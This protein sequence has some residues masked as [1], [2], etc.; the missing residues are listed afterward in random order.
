VEITT[1]KIIGLA[2]GV[3]CIYSLWSSLT[4]PD[5]L[6]RANMLVTA[7]VSGITGLLLLFTRIRMINHPGVITE[8]GD[9]WNNPARFPGPFKQN[10]RDQTRLI[11]CMRQFRKI[12]TIIST[13][14]GRL[15]VD[16][17]IS[18]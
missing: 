11:F 5:F 17:Y 8:V 9:A 4:D 7:L 15:W 12:R 13:R 16:L 3:L 6:D 10:V 1:R 18:K 2:L 14:S